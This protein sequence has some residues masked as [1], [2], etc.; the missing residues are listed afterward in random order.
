MKSAMAARTAG[1]ARG[2]DRG[3]GRWARS[4]RPTA[5]FRTY[6]SREEEVDDDA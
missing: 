5:A 6:P 1:I 2:V 3:C 4:A